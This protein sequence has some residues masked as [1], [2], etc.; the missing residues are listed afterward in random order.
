M[1]KFLEHKPALSMLKL[2]MGMKSKSS[3]GYSNFVDE[4]DTLLLEGAKF[5][6]TMEYCVAVAEST[7]PATVSVF[8]KF[9]HCPFAIHMYIYIYTLYMSVNGEH[10]IV[11]WAI[12][13]SIA[14]Q[15]LWACKTTNGNNLQTEE[16]VLD[17]L[18]L[19]LEKN[20]KLVAYHLQGAASARKRFEAI[21]N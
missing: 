11:M 19:E 21:V 14:P 15:Q 6:D 20:K 8:F 3:E 18:A 5:Y 12:S 13:M 2:K 10:A 16:S 4:L 1:K 9:K 17:E 7:D